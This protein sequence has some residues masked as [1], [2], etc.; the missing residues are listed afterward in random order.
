V[1]WA[2]ATSR[3]IIRDFIPNKLIFLENAIVISAALEFQC[4]LPWA[5]GLT[6]R[7]SLSNPRRKSNMSF[8]RLGFSSIAELPPGPERGGPCLTFRSRQEM[9]A[10]D[11]RAWHGT[12]NSGADCPLD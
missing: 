6:D 11:T 3:R 4:V 8:L 5:R 1:A 10:C 2:R 7:G 9:P 12:E